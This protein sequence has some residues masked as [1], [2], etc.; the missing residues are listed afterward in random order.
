MV[1]STTPPA[2]LLM[3]AF[4]TVAY[5]VISSPVST[6]V[7]GAWRVVTV[8]A[9]CV[10]GVIVTVV[11]AEVLAVKSSLVGRNLARIW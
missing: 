2:R 11:G 3:P 7:V 1:N 8:G 5:R 6:P 4:W 9:F 10:R